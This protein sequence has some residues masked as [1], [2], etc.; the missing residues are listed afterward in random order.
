MATGSLNVRGARLAYSDEGSGPIVV[1]AHGLTKSRSAD[2]TL[3]LVDWPALPA[4]GFRLISYDARGHG[5]SEGTPVTDAYRWESL[6]EDLLAV[7]DHFSPAE[8]VRAAGI[9]MG[10]GTILNALTQ[11]PE[12][13]AAVMLGAP[14]TAWETRA[15]QRA[16][17]EQFAQQ[18]EQ[19]SPGQAAAMFAQA[20]VPQIFEHVPGYG[21]PTPA[22]ELLPSIFRGGGASD[23]PS[24]RQL[25]DVRVPALI[26][27]W[28]T[29]P[30]HP[31]STTE[32]LAEVLPASTFHVS[33]TAE[34]VRTWAAKA[35]AFFA[36]MPET[37]KESAGRLGNNPE[38]EC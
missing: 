14:P 35:A 27:A 21:V 33:D 17:Y 36:G 22:H 32:R 8:P 29:D 10:T 11:A 2:R 24:S 28:A 5:E 38:T 15:A 6:A 25:A 3:G 23:L 1:Y 9:S 26:L 34:D 20:P 13:F 4:A 18:V 12:R 31:I 7:I 19:M 37:R 16:Q 30:A